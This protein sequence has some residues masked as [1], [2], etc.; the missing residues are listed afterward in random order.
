MRLILLFLNLCLIESFHNTM[1]SKMQISIFK[2]IFGNHLTTKMCSSS[3]ENDNIYVVEFSKEDSTHSKDLEVS[4]VT[5]EKKDDELVS[6][7]VSNNLK[8][9]RREH[10]GG[11]D[12]RDIG[13]TCL[14]KIYD[15]IQEKKTLEK[16]RKYRYQ[17]NLLKKLQNCQ[18]GE[19]EKIRA[20]EE[21]NYI[22]E[23][24]KYIS[25]IEAGGLYKNWTNSNF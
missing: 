11:F 6:I 16:L 9:M 15:E 21:Y 2:N 13:K 12:Q 18:V 10:G 8:R 25:N 24:S 7:L 20:I 3:E 4:T 22:M 23:S 17:I 1:F 19:F 14:E 5:D